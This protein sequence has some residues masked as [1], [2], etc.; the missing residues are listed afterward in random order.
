MV[1]V[2]MGKSKGKK[3]K[4]RR[5][6]RKNVRERGKTS[7][8]KVIQEFSEGTR[9]SIEIDPG[10]TKGQPHPKF[11]GRTGIITGKQGRAYVVDIKEGNK[12]KE[13]IA[14]PEHLK[15]VKD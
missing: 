15:K 8:E 11:H 5:K 7:L 2:Q 14:R 1:G 3:S 12:S 10:V 4:T 9:V 6:L 13:V